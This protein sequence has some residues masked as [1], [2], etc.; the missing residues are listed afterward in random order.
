MNFSISGMKGAMTGMHNVVKIND[1]LFWV[2][3]S[4]RRISLFEN[5]YP[6][7]RGVSY[8]SYLLKDEKN[9]LFDTADAAVKD[10]LIENIDYLLGDDR[11]DY[12]V[13][14]HM[15]PDHCSAIAVLCKKYPEMKIVCNK[16]AYNM[17]VQF[18]GEQ[19]LSRVVFVE[20]GDELSSGRHTLHFV[21]APMVHWPEAMVTY[22]SLDKILFSA[23]AFGTFG[24]LNGNIF[25]DEVNFD[26]VWMDEARRYYANIVGKYGNQVQALLKKASKLDIEMICPLHGPIWRSGFSK[27][28][29]KYQKW[30]TYTPEEKSVMIAYGSI[31]GNT[32]NAAEILAAKL[33]EAGI[34]NI[35]MY[36]VSNTHPSVIV[37]E[38]FRCS[39]LIFASST[40]NAGIFSNMETVLHDLAA[41]NI[42][43]RT[44]GFIENGSWAPTSGG[45]M[46]DIFSGLKNINFLNNTLSI[47]SSLTSEN[48]E[49]IERMASEIA[50]SVKTE[51]IA[52]QVIDKNAMF[53][54]SYGL[55][56]LT[57]RDNAKDNGCIINTVMQITS[58]PNRIAIA[59][60]KANFTHDII[61]KTGVFNVSI[62]DESVPFATFERYGFCSGRD[63]DKFAD[64]EGEYRT[65]NGIR[66]I[67]DHTN[68]VISANVRD[69]YDYGSHTLFIADVTEA[70]AFTNTTSVTYDYYFKNIKPKPQPAEENKKGFVC[71][72]CGYVYEGDTL[73]ADFICPL[74]KHG[75]EDFEPLN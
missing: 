19:D 57:A 26:S 52:E 42:Q 35:A 73:P 36:D 53:K 21:M 30:S 44:V 67:K 45:L 40:Y 3:A 72:I 66:Y 49:N 23:D 5:V 74:C 46:R 9:V 61:V 32:Q 15:E 33:A 2:G 62:L 27:L 43:N 28:I 48:L 51:E 38:A 71:K 16:K 63:T 69:M 55:F 22:D 18:F 8:N 41:H 64:E 29:E 7:S 10:R 25:A 56:V 65:A 1:D 75:V 34:R 13:V 58:D 60:N 14:N 6:V 47:K 54:L 12:L 39:H 20:E 31:Y 70:E 68:A 4:D 24:A 37:A 50:E 17:I 11:L 59:V